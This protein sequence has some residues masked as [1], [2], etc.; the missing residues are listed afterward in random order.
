MEQKMNPCIVYVQSTVTVWPG[1]SDVACLCL[2]IVYL[3]LH[4]L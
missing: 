3:L 4:V 1:C 2:A